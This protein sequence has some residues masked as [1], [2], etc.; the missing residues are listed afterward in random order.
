MDSTRLTKYVF[1]WDRNQSGNRWS[2]DIKT[3]CDA[4]GLESVYTNNS[5][6]NENQL[7]EKINL[8]ENQKWKDEVAN[9]PKLRLYNNIKTNMVVEEYIKRSLT[10]VERSH[11]AQLRSGTLKINVELGRMS[12]LNLQERSCPI[13]K[14]GSI[15]DELHLLFRC[16]A[17]NEGRQVFM[18]ALR[19]RG[20]CTITSNV[21]SQ[22]DT[23]KVVCESAPKQ[24]AKF[25]MYCMDKRRDALY[26]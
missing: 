16:S 7:L 3:I 6:C 8:Y 5:M 2:T 15:E 1:Q 12:G 13:C 14:D 18:R 9:K 25:V 22:T 20:L 4:I 21:T 17:Y 23:L 19:E 11:M 26:K 24:L 10:R